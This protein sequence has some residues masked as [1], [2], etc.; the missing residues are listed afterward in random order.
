MRGEMYRNTCEMY[1]NTCD[2][3]RNTCE[4]YRNTSWC[5]TY[6]F[7]WIHVCV[8]KFSSIYIRVC[9]T[10]F[11][12]VEKE[13][14]L[15]R[16]VCEDVFKYISTCI[17]KPHLTNFFFYVFFEPQRNDKIRF[18]LCRNTFFPRKSPLH[19]GSPNASPE[20]VHRPR[21]Q[22]PLH[23]DIKNI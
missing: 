2:M 10:A 3:Y 13:S 19:F 9:W 14:C 20:V 1:R 23:F 17:L 15:L 4:M 7:T 18:F 11:V 21:S 8:E 6:T 12:R 5:V 16:C 22:S